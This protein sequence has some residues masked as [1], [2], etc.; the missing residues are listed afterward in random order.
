MPT[1]EG[2]VTVAEFAD[3]TVE[4]VPA[5]TISRVNGKPSLTLQVMPA[6]GANVVDISHGVNAE[7]DRLAP[8]LDAEFVTIFDQA[9]TSSSR[10]TTSPSRA[11]SVCSS[12]CS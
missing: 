8:I 9:P 12:R 1:S 3:V 6:Q 10:S 2:A 4:T 5:E 11:G 7:L